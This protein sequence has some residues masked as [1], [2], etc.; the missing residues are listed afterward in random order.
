MQ[1]LFFVVSKLAWPLIRPDAL[2]LFAFSFALFLLWRGR[3]R[4]A[5]RLLTL[6][7]VIAWGLSFIP[8]GEWLQQPLD[9]RFPTNPVLPTEVDGIIVLAGAVITASSDYWQ[10]LQT[11][12]SADR[13][14]HF[15]ALA[16]R[17]PQARLVFTGGS[18]SLIG[19]SPGEAELV[20]S[21]LVQ[22]GIAAERLV[23]ENKSRNTAENVLYSKRLVQPQP[24]E[25]WVLVTSANHMPRSVGLFCKHDWPVIP[26]PVDHSSVPDRALHPGFNPIQHVQDLTRAV[27]E[28]MGLTAY[29]ISGKIDHWLPAGCGAPTRVLGQ[30]SN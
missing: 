22:S 30:S 1:D 7:L 19:E 21:T 15:I 13:L 16:R 28:W 23:L 24:G 4:P 9:Q 6:L 11:N 5:R 27:H 26:Y 10:Q 29:Y 12:E 25:R 8:V 18:A 20:R 14:I 17:F 2:L 3:L